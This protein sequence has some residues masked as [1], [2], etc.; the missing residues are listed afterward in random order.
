LA[1]DFQIRQ[2]LGHD[3]VAQMKIRVRLSDT[4][5]KTLDH[6]SA[7]ARRKHLTGSWFNRHWL[8][9]VLA[10]ASFL[11]R[12]SS[13]IMLLDKC[14]PV[15]LCASPLAGEVCFSINE[16]NL[17]SLRQELAASP[18]GWDEDEDAQ[19]EGL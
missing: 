17:K 10:I 3:F 18:T 4:K 6:A 19:E 5:G 12:G 7:I 1:P 9:R 8:N 16:A 14:D 13:R 11:S 15:V 2:D